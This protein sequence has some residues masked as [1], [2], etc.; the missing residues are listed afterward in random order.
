MSA[1]S[2]SRDLRT[3]I[4][5]ARRLGVRGVEIDARGGLDPAEV[6]QTGRRHIRKWLDDAGLRVSA[7]SFRTRGGYAD[8]DRLEGRVAAT[9]A[10][11]ELAHGLGATVVLNHVGDVPPPAEPQ[12]AA[13]PRW[14]LLI[15]VLT[16]IGRHGQ[17]VG[18]TLCVEAGRTG[19]DDL[20]RII[21][22]LP[23]AA[24]SCDLVSGALLVHGHDPVQ[25][26]E[27]LGRHIGFVHA[28][29]AVPGGFAG[30]G[31]PAELGRGHVDV[32]A[33]L[34]ALEERGYRGWIGVEP[35]DPAGGAAEI[36]AAIG[37]L[38]RL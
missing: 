30:H 26:V 18:A 10:A 1:G 6:S 25:V 33:V 27:K 9:K 4:E 8:H 34:G 2:L 3:A 21:D 31:R 38:N 14:Q 36:A 13:D 23:E 35:A 29:D 24:I 15:D 19:P 12:A 20:A 17:R 16:D 22:H 37:F 5:V 32:A 11:L 7:V 28:T